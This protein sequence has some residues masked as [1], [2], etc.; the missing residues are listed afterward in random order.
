[1]A[2]FAF[3]Y[4]HPM[5]DG[6]GRVH[7][8][9][10]ND[11]LRRDGVVAEP[12]ILPVSAVISADVGE[13]RAY[14]KVLDQVSK[15]LMSAI[16]EQVEFSN[17]QTAFPDGV[18]SNFGFNAQDIG[19]P[20]WRHPDLGPHIVYLSKVIA[21]TIKEEMRQESKYLM[22]HRRA[23]EAIK[24]IVEMPDQQAD[25]LI[26]SIE[27]NDAKLSN[28]LAKEMP[29]LA[30]LGIWESITDAVS[31]AF[32]GTEPKDNIYDARSGLK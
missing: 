20:I 9:L 15:P 14:D 29:V 10:I 30:G 13:R 4:I 16:R 17:V 5:A 23:R 18:V 22:G 21:R 8:F 11:I 19:R 7:R 27:Q 26:R 2:A 12:V 1:V 24:E 32:N 25:R 6:N 28:V 31:Q 3:V